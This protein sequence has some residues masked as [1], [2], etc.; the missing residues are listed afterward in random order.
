MTDLAIIS[1]SNQ[2]WIESNLLCNELRNR[3][4]VVVNSSRD[5]SLKSQ[6]RYANQIKSKFLMVIGDNEIANQ[7]IE[8][9]ELSTGKNIKIKLDAEEIFLKIRPN[10]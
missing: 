9:K 4:L 8:L 5:K 6:M 2:A 3:N 10:G 1:L 7:E